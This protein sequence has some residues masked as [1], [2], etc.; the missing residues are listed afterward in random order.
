MN[1]QEIKPKGFLKNFIQCF[2]FYKTTNNP[3]KHTILP[4]GYF[5]LIIE[6]E[7]DV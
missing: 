5:D 6:F 2:W 4:D 3:I 7:D 1:Y